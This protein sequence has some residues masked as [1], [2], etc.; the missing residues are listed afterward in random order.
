M[1][2][3]NM[4]QKTQIK[5]HPGT[6]DTYSDDVATH[7]SKLTDRP[8]EETSRKSETKS[9]TNICVNDTKPWS[10][11]HNLTFVAVASAAMASQNNQRRAMGVI[12]G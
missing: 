3:R 2:L 6:V 9:I 5:R 7:K 4:H 8:N 12:H 1:R 10:E 11:G